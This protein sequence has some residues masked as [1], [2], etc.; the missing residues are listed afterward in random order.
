MSRHV[1]ANPISNLNGYLPDLKSSCTVLGSALNYLPTLILNGQNHGQNLVANN[2]QAPISWDK[3]TRPVVSL[4]H[5]PL[6]GGRQSN[7]SN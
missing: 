3:I 7:N 4:K 1:K 6:P 5:K 2:W